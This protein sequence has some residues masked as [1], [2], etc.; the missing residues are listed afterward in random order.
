MP[1]AHPMKTATHRVPRVERLRRAGG[2]H[3]VSWPALGNGRT[4]RVLQS[5]RRRTGH[6]PSLGDLGHQPDA[7]VRRLLQ[8]ALARDLG[9]VRVHSSAQARALLNAAGADAVTSGEHIT[10]RPEHDHANTTGGQVLLLHE[11]VHVLQQRD[12]PGLH[13]DAELPAHL[14]DE[15]RAMA[16]RLGGVHDSGVAPS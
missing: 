3:P 9:D 6:G 12:D 5:L 2:A 8:S 11:L 13:E 16:A 10:I 15:A 1:L 14:E 7:A 4:G